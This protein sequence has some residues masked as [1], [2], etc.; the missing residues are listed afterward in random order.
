MMAKPMKPKC[1]EIVS[2][3]LGRHVTPGESAEILSNL[4]AFMLS[5]KRED[6]AKWNSMSYE[7]RVR[8][9]GALYQQSLLEEAAKVR[10]RAYRSIIAQADVERSRANAHRRGYK[11]FSAG[12]E[13]LAEVDRKVMAAQREVESDFAVVL[14]GKQK[15][16]LGIMEDRELASAVVREVFGEDTGSKIAKDVAEAWNELSNAGVERFNRAGGNLGKIDRYVPQTH[17]AQRMAHAVEVIQGHGVMRQTAN[18]ALDATV[19]RGDKTRSFEANRDAWVEYILPKLDRTRYLDENGDLLDDEGMREMLRNVFQTILSDGTTEFEASTVA[20]ARQGFGGTSRAN[21]GDLHRAIHFKDANSFLEYHHMFGNGTIFGNMRGSLR[22]TAKDAALLESLGPNPNYTVRGLKR[23]CDAENRVNNARYANAPEIVRS[24]KLGVSEHY[25]DSAWDTLNGSASLVAPGRHLIAASMG[26]ARNLE[27]VGKLQSTF[28]SSMTDIPSYFISAG[29]NK[30]PFMTALTN[31]VTAWGPDAKK[32]AA[33]AGLMADELS[34]TFSRFG[35]NNVGEGWTGMLANATMKLSLLDAFTNG[36]RR[37]S[38]INMMGA[39]ADITSAH[40]WSSIEAFTK[41]QL[42]RAGVTE[43][44][45]LIWSAA[46]RDKRSISDPA[47]YLTREGI[48]EVTPETLAR[49]ALEN[50]GVTFRRFDIDHAATTYIAFLTDESGMASLSPD[51]GTRALSN[52]AGNRGTIGGEIFRSFMLFKTFPISF[53]RRHIERMTDL[54]ET[55]GESARIRYAATVFTLMTL[56]GALSVQL[57]ALSAG[58]DLQ[59]PESK[60]F[61]LQAVSLGGGAGFLTD[62]IVAGVDGQNA[63]GSPNFLRFMG[64]VTGTVLDTFDLA[65]TFYNERV[66]SDEGGLYN[67]E[68]KAEGKALRL[69]RGHMPFVN[70][71]YLKGAVDRAVYND[72]MEAASPGYLARV[73]SWSAKNTG[74]GH[75]WALDNIVPERAPEV[76]DSPKE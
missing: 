76:A 29:L 36:V 14:D 4:K 60:D 5:A 54:A 53:M 41:R 21:R 2:D 50:P 44:D 75:W 6:P 27:V 3:V 72:L 12:M 18:W 47:G 32:F 8:Q 51:L 35:A 11:G 66:G 59:D 22:R 43:K 71:W 64:P 15:G 48:R 69:V 9:A 1:I 61:W 33:R 40:K 63:Y 58:R 49:I 38:M 65:K 23:V 30:V 20:G 31:L 16:V 26:G 24:G 45:W 17:N 7:E 52:V 46:K 34:G 68:S 28:L 57:K 39:M 19:R 74:Q 13:V 37:A 10:Q 55:R 67:R 73:E 42:E 62:L 25:F 70:L 56:A